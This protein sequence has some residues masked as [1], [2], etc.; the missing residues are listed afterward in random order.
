MIDLMKTTVKAQAY[1]SPYE[2][3]PKGD[4]EAV[5]K[6]VDEWRPKVNASLKVFEFDNSGRKVVGP[7]G[8]DV[9][10]MEQDVTTYSARVAFEI[11]DGEH[12]GAV[13]Y[14]YLNLHPNQPWGLPAFLDACNVGDTNPKEVQTKC[15]NAYVTLKVDTEISNRTVVD[16]TTGLETL[17]ARERNV[18]KSVRKSTSI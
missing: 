4:Y 15:K 18:V 3:L 6:S 16:P 17:E 10:T 5:V 8:K 11:T 12:R 14:Y 13:L 7:D 9:F 2:L 1:K